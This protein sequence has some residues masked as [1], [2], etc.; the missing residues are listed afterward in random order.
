MPLINWRNR[1]IESFVETH[2]DPS[3]QKIQFHTHTR[4]DPVD[5]IQ[6][7]EKELIDSAAEHGYH[8]LSITCHNAVVFDEDLQK[9]AEKKGILL[10][11]GIEKSI[12]K[13][14]VLIIN[15][16]HEAQKIHSFE[17]LRKYKNTHPDCLIVAPHPYYPAWICL[18]KKLEQYI[19]LFDAIEYSWYHSKKIDF[20]NKKAAGVAKKYNLPMLGTSDNHILKD[21]DWTYSIVQAEKN[22][23]AIF[24]AI[25]KNQIRIVSRPASLWKLITNICRIELRFFV[26]RFLKKR[27]KKWYNDGKNK[28]PS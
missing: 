22:I 13:R 21:L 5:N 16:T 1:K 2:C 24:E 28:I 17:D 3:L 8:A 20:F 7:S 6:H 25:K 18:Q 19:E 15:A 14:H 10:I 26:K 23:P 12:G 11:P 27:A 4:Q 9:Y